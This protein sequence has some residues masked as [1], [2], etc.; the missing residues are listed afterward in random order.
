[1]PYSRLGAKLFGFMLTLAMAWCFN[2]SVRNLVWGLWAYTIPVFLT[3][4]MVWVG[5]PLI[6]AFKRP[7]FVTAL[8]LM[9]FMIVTGTTLLIR[10]IVPFD[11]LSV[12]A[13]PFIGLFLPMLI[14]G[15]IEAVCSTTS[16]KKHGYLLILLP[17]LLLRFFLLTIVVAVFFGPASPAA[18]ESMMTF[19][20]LSLVFFIPFELM[21]FGI[22]YNKAGKR[23]APA[24]D[25]AVWPRHLR[26]DSFA[27]VLKRRR[28]R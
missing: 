20:L 22:A 5:L 13:S 24:S 25:E 21:G 16:K 4:F 28:A 7:R 10:K 14:A 27:A 15:A 19:I 26:F 12:S 8:V 3:F 1:M 9:F 11:G 6:K 17:A 2:W 18:R 23:C